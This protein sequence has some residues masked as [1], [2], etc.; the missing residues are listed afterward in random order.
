MISFVIK[1]F[2]IHRELILFS[3]EPSLRLGLFD[4]YIQSF[5]KNTKFGFKRS[6]KFTKLIDLTSQQFTDSFDK[7]TLYEIRRA[8]L[9][10]IRCKS[11]VNIKEYISFYNEFINKKNLTSF[12][13]EQELKRYSNAFILRVAYLDGDEILVFHSYLI[14]MTI[15]RVRLLNSVSNI[16]DNTLNP[17]RKSLIGRANRLLHF[18]DMLYFKELGFITYDF[19]GYAYNT[20]D[21]SLMGINHFKDSFGGILVEESNY[22]SYLI[23]AFKAISNN[24][25]KIVKKN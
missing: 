24:L 22:E 10:G 13:S 11:S 7:K 17:S 16:H 9:E 14:D 23:F 4:N 21:K 5:Y 15:K 25:L 18:E 8:T 19:G 20:K 6:V 12:L 1:Q 3:P 2:P